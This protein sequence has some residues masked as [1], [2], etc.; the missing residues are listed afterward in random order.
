MGS[1]IAASVVV[2]STQTRG[3][4]VNITLRILVSICFGLVLSGCVTTNAAR[5]GT[6]TASR[7]PVPPEQVALYRLA[8]QV[9][10]QYE[11]VALLNSSGDSGFTNE[12]GM[13]E[14]MRKKAG[15][16]GANAVILDAISEPGHGAK[17]AAAIFGV[18]AQRK[19]KAIAI[20]VFPGTQ[21][22]PPVAATQPVPVNVPAP[23]SASGYVPPQDP[24]KTCA[25]CGQ[26]GREL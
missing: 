11:E 14:S 8:S 26:I 22:V 7:P 10:G 5:L 21:P 19:G 20:W 6:T 23:P 3:N 15:Q 4:T 24:A 1:G 12:A 25:A 17:V 18:S 16:M 2:A 13:Y 9:P